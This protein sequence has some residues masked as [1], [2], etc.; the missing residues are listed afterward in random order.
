MIVVARVG[1]PLAAHIAR[2]D[3]ARV[4]REV[5]AKRRILDDY[6][7]AVSACRNVTGAELDTPGYRAMCAGRDALKS[8]VVQI[9]AVWSDHPGYRQEWKP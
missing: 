7:I 8:C 3:P 4:L 9:A 2:H 5:E 1:T 6:R